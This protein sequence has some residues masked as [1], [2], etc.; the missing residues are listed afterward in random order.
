MLDLDRFRSLTERI[1]ECLAYGQKVLLRGMPKSGRSYVADA[2]AADV[3]RVLDIA[4]ARFQRDID[5]A[6]L[7]P[8]L[9]KVIT[10]AR[11]GLGVILID[12]FG[13]LLRSADGATWQ[14][15]LNSQCVD[16]PH[17]KSIGMLITCGTGE[18][19][20][21]IGLPGSPVVDSANVVLFTPILPRGDVISALAA[22]GTEITRATN[23]VSEYGGHLAL[24]A[25][26][27]ASDT[28]R[29]VGSYVEEVL[30]EAV[31]H[32]APEAAERLLDLARRPGRQ[33]ASIPVD[34]GL[35][36][37]VFH[38]EAGA[39][40]LVPALRQAGLGNLLIGGA[41]SWPSELKASVRRF[42][43]RTYGQKRVLW[44]DRYFGRG[45][46]RLMTVL[47]AVAVGW[48][49]SELQLLG[50]NPGVEDLPT[51]LLEEFQVRQSAWRKQGLEV[52]W[53]VIDDGDFARMHDRQL[54][55][56]ERT[57]GYSMPPCTRMIG[58]DPVGNAVDAYLPR[59]PVGRLLDAWSRS[60]LFAKG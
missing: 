3:E 11:R 58:H 51:H 43:A 45:C 28:A 9:E 50:S 40:Q 54:V 32:T 22:S 16:G 38:P 37:L 39:T 56:A 53:H 15:R 26:A 31:A 14:T 25:K 13:T 20:S 12:G 17:A 6:A 8:G 49:A 7:E 48:R 4:P 2:V 52:A 5:I 18:S 55:S 33:L 1:V 27:A 21:R 42:Q 41:E 23:L 47:D 34:Q 60:R 59:A 35:A 29:A 46:R 44:F 36:P 30:L 24:V 19:L 10:D 57:D